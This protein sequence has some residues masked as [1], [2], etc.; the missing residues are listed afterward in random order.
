MPNTTETTTPTQIPTTPE[1]GN[2]VRWKSQAGGNWKEKEGVVLLEVPEN[3]S[4]LP[5]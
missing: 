2:Y 4:T 5:N 3:T 1:T